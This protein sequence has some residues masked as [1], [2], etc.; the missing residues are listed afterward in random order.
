MSLRWKKF[1]FFEKEVVKEPGSSLPHLKLKARSPAPR[2]ARG[3]DT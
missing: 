3:A 1:S 2:R